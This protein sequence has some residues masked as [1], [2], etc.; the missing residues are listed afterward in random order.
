M[1]IKDIY[2][3]LI[4]HQLCVECPSPVDGLCSAVRRAV[5]TG[6]EGLSVPA[7]QAL[8]LAAEAVVAYSWHG[9]MADAAGLRETL[10]PLLNAE[11]DDA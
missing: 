5:E 3:A 1:T 9:L 11:G 8:D 2:S 10:A 6:V 4:E 7:L